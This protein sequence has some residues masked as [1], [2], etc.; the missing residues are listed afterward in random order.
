MFV[1]VSTLKQVMDVISKAIH[2][3][4]DCVFSQGLIT[5]ETIKY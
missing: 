3:D 2:N 5:G 4:F 1:T